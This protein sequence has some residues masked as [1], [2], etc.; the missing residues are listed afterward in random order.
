MKRIWCII[1]VGCIVFL[2]LTSCSHLPKEAEAVYPIVEGRRIP[3]E[4]LFVGS[5]GK[6]N[7]CIV[8]RSRQEVQQALDRKV[9]KN[10]GSYEKNLLLEQ[11][12]AIHQVICVNRHYHS[13]VKKVVEV[14]DHNGLGVVYESDW[15]EGDPIADDVK[16]YKTTALLIRKSDYDFSHTEDNLN[17]AFTMYTCYI[18]DPDKVGV[19]PIG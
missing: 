10:I 9:L 11:N 13:S 8:F 19:V 15:Q 6:N 18:H 5:H 3:F 12:Y 7:G 17:V 2:C 14:V 16:E 4:I 1:L